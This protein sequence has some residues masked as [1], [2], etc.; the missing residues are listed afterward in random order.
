LCRTNT[1]YPYFRD[2]KTIVRV[3]RVQDAAPPWELRKIGIDLCLS[4]ASRTLEDGDGISQT[5]WEL[6]SSFGRRLELCEM[7]R[8]PEDGDGISQ[9]SW[10]LKS[11]FGRRLELCEMSRTPE[12]GD[13]ISQT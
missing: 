7:S 6:K 10:E 13:G 11:S 12:D 2:A 8:T 5:S 1:P 4:F 3:E 9:T